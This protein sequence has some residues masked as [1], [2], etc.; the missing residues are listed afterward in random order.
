MAYWARML[1]SQS[2]RGGGEKESPPDSDADR[3]W[4]RGGG[5][6]RNRGGGEKKGLHGGGLME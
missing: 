3:N 5:G 1:Q 6:V 2:E 4:E